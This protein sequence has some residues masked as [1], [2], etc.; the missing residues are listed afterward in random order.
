MKNRPRNLP[1][2]PAAH[3]EA[4]EPR[5]MLS[6]SSAWAVVTHATVAMSSHGTP[7]L[8][9]TPAISHSDA[10]PADT[11]KIPSIADPTAYLSRSLSASQVSTILAQAAS[12][13]LNG[14][15]ITVSDREGNILGQV[16]VGTPAPV[17]STN[18]LSLDNLKAESVAR[19]RTAG[20]FE[21]TQN[22][23]TTRTARFIIQDN[24]PQ[25]IPNTPG[26]PL[27]GVEFSDIPG[28]DVIVP[29][30]TQAG[31]A[32]KLVSTLGNVEM[33]LG[34]LSGDPGGVPLFVD[35]I[36]VG[37]IGVS[38]GGDDIAVRDDL[39]SILKNV[40]KSFGSSNVPSE[41]T[42]VDEAVALSGA[43]GFQPNPKI[44]ANDIVVGGLIFPYAAE[45]P[46]T[47]HAFKSFGALKRTGAISISSS[48]I[49]APAAPFPEISFHVPHIPG[50]VGG[51]LKNLA[52][53]T[54]P[55][56][57]GDAF[58]QNFG[59]VAGK[60]AHGQSLSTDDVEQVI[61]N[62]VSTALL[63]RGGI[64]QPIGV[65]IRVHVSVVDVNGDQLADFRMDDGTIFSNDVAVQKARTA[66]FFSD[67]RH[68]LS[69]RSVGFLAQGHFPVG[70]NTG[71]FGPLFHLQNA[72]SVDLNGQA[73]NFKNQLRNGITIFPGGA[74]LYKNGILVGAVGISGDGVDQDDLVAFGGTDGFR[75]APKIRV[76]HLAGSD[77]SAFLSQKIRDLVDQG[78]NLDIFK[79]LFDQGNTILGDK[80]GR[81][82]EGTLAFVTADHFLERLAQGLDG[83]KLPFQK[84]PRN[85]KI[86]K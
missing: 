14:Q 54:E 11:G 20:F 65:P 31:T 79:T 64:R 32:T 48:I 18:D 24:F 76:D 17:T 26:G 68:A 25:G 78:F 60:G 22:A 39:Q 58:R 50:F 3:F 52:T 35:G 73:I 7:S 9:L 44:L 21:S 30:Q 47:V 38:G 71:G 86:N 74:P 80:K 59:V 8:T 63:N 29:S 6:A 36:P 13:A 40:T 49:D 55:S 42:D 34:D 61:R 77:V 27:Y 83:V 53:P 46:R 4:L 56:V 72:L 10:F 37:G 51:Q 75:A 15:V 62:A 23:F 12:Q 2:R 28:T 1:S 57:A 67:N 66:L 85:P 82:T 5:Q 33:Q 81:D 19:A 84:F 16:V 69:S 70:T 41:E 43:Q 45:G